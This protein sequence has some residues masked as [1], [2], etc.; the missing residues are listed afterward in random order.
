[1]GFSEYYEL[2]KQ[3]RVDKDMF[4][5]KQSD[6]LAHFQAWNVVYLLLSAIVAVV[7]FGLAFLDKAERLELVGIVSLAAHSAVG[8]LVGCLLC[9]LGWFC[10]VK[11]KGCCGKA[12]YL[13]WGVVY[14]VFMCWPLLQGAAGMNLVCLLLLVPACAMLWALFNLWQGNAAGYLLPS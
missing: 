12:G 4:Q 14:L 13:A 10:V 7:N 9:H 2:L 11:Q 6:W 5:L 8:L 1:M 3:P